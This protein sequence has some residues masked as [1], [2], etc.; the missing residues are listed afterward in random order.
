VRIP[1]TVQIGG[2]DYGVEVVEVVSPENALAGQVDHHAKAIRIKGGFVHSGQEEILLHECLH[3][4][5]EQ[6][7]LDITEE[8]LHRLSEATYALIKRNRLYFG[9]EK[10]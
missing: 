3:T 7:H 10:P 8:T 9:L 2:H 4:I 6:L 1:R 5:C